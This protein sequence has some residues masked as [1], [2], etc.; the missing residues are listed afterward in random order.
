MGILPEGMDA[1]SLFFSFVIIGS[2]GYQV[3]YMIS[4]QRIRKIMEYYDFDSSAVRHPFILFRV[5][6]SQIIA[7]TFLFLAGLFFLQTNVLE[8]R[9]EE[10]LSSAEQQNLFQ[11]VWSTQS[12]QY[13]SLIIAAVW[14]GI[15]ILM[16]HSRRERETR[17]EISKIEAAAGAAPANGKPISSN[18]AKPQVIGSGS[19]VK[20]D[21]DKKL[22]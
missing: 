14:F 4:P 18:A 5:Q 20:A 10:A 7:M 22:D 21:R 2:I 3:L 13:Q 15:K 9:K 16:A 1:F 6:M 11:Q 17:E 8:E 19:P 12:Y